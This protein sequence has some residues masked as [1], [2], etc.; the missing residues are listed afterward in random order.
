MKAADHEIHGQSQGKTGDSVR[1][2]V[3]CG[4]H[5]LFTPV[6]AIRQGPCPHQGA[7]LSFGA[8]AMAPRMLGLRRVVAARNVAARSLASDFTAESPL[9]VMP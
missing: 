9:P 1:K 3:E 4:P 6:R 5:D 7:N 2:Q 8:H